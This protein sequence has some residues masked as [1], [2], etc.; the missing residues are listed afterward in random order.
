MGATSEEL[1][2]P[3]STRKGELKA[4]PHPALKI[5]DEKHDI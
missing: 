4:P 3:H 2:D 1:P 5:E